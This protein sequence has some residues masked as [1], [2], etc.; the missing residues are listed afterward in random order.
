MQS[1]AAPDN[2]S[3]ERSNMFV[4]GTLYASGGSTPVRIRNLSRRGALV[5]AAGLPPAG[6]TVRLSRGRLS[7]SGAMM[8]VTGRKG[9]VKLASAVSA[10]D[11]MPMGERGRGQQLIDE[12]MHRARLGSFPPAPID[13]APRSIPSLRAELVRLH[14]LLLAANEE[15]ASEDA[16]TAAQ[17]IAVQ[18]IDGVANSLAHLADQ[19]GAALKRR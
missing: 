8:W 7:V 1:A 10:G 16:L 14:Q 11:W 6:T 15:L 3:D 12:V 19:V 2:R 5:E 9:G 4:T 18:T 17:V 13:A